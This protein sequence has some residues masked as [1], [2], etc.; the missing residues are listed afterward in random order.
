[1]R[2]TDKIQQAKGVSFNE[3]KKEIK[4][5]GGMQHGSKNFLP[6]RL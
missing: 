6:G 3:Y 1:M 4:I 5:L 2:R